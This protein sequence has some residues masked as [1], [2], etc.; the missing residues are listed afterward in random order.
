MNLFDL[1]VNMSKRF[2][3]VF[4]SLFIISALLSACFKA[5]DEVGTLVPGGGTNP[6][7]EVVLP[8]VEPPGPASFTL[9]LT[10][11]IDS[12]PPDSGYGS[13]TATNLNT[14]LA[15]TA[16][17]LVDVRQPSEIETNGYIAGAINIPIR[18]LLDNLDK[19]PGLVSPIVIYDDTGHRGSMGMMALSMLGYTNV[20]NLYGGIGAWKTASLPLVT[21]SLPPEA[22]LLSVRIVTDESMFT[23]L[24]VFLN[25]LPTGFLGV[26]TDALVTELAG[27]EPPMLLDL[28]KLFEWEQG[29]LTGAT[30]FDFNIMMRHLDELPTDKNTKIVVY[31]ANG[32][33]GG[34][35]VLALNLLG[36]TNVR[37]LTGG[38]YSWI[39]SGQPTIK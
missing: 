19:L 25:A 36:Y 31:C 2:S 29:H 6:T 22:T 20:R 28:R 33:R 18:D 10:A 32:H 7:L 30:M 24:N 11:F 1:E 39:A 34:M 5:T 35:A 23:A 13:V 38:I 12:I 8:S 9:Q 16:P 3:L 17:F 27:S 26:K 21:G 14:E 4:I 37:N 15:G